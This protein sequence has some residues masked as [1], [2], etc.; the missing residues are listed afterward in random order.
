MDNHEIDISEK[1]ILDRSKGDALAKSLV[2]LQ[3]TWFIL[4]ATT[5]V[6]QHL[7][8]AILNFMTYFCWW[9]KPLDVNYTIVL[10]AYHN[11]SLTV[12]RLDTIVE[13]ETAPTVEENATPALD[14]AATSDLVINE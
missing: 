10:K 14:R 8:F 1:E 2:L 13:P 4:Q 7:A 3:A 5:S 9:N 6:V 11:P 12:R